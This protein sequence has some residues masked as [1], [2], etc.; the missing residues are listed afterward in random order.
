MTGTELRVDVL[1]AGSHASA[2]RVPCR[3]GRNLRFETAGLR[4]YCLGDWNPRIFDAFVVAAAV[5]FCD[6]L[7]SRPPV[8]W[9][10][11]LDLRVP[12]HDPPLWAST[13][14]SSP[15]IR[16]LSLQT[17]DRWRF[18]FTSRRTKETARQGVLDLPHADEGVLP[19]SNGL[20]SHMVAELLAS[21]SGSKPLRV[22]LGAS[23][24]AGNGADTPFRSVP[25]R[26]RHAPRRAA[27]SSARSRGFRF[28][29]LG[30]V[31][32]YLA[33][34]HTVVV[35]ESGQ[36]ALGPSLVPVGQLPPDHRS[37]PAFLLL[38]REFLGALLDYDFCYD[39]PRLWNTKGE[40]LQE[41]LTTQ[42][43]DAS[44]RAT[45]SCWQGSRHVSVNEKRRQCGVCAACMLRRMSVHAAGATE[46]EDGYVWEN[47]GA[48]CYEAGAAP[49]FKN[50]SP[51]GA[52][53]EHAI[54]GTL[55]LEHLALLGLRHRESPKLSTHVRRLSRSLGLSRQETSEKLHRMLTK[56]AQEWE[57]FLDHLGTD[58]FITKW[59]AEIRDAYA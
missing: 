30:G 11:R 21:P 9:S 2:G 24:P 50:R 48:D 55:H 53:H 56:H 44:W 7:R 39:V 3:I 57:N 32:A 47:L 37:H 5:Q 26:V 4:S 40:T 14:V 38:M 28:A 58:S 17:G 51:N 6:G 35:P 41:L 43:N 54:A 10:R 15:L 18:H 27:E 12:V 59:V 8:S 1:E 52:L 46:E 16:A 45:R 13:G 42:P 23:A 29:L 49:A 25:Y 19:F 31:A 20:D 34:T 22:R 33:G 36:G